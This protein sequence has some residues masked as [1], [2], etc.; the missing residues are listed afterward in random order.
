MLPKD[1]PP[2]EMPTIR[3]TNNKPTS[4]ESSDAP[5]AVDDSLME[6]ETK[7]DIETAS[8]DTMIFKT[9]GI[10]PHLLHSLSSIF[11]LALES[12]Q[13]F[14]K[15]NGDATG[16]KRRRRVS[17][18]TTDDMGRDKCK[19]KQDL[20]VIFILYYFPRKNAKPIHSFFPSS[21]GLFYSA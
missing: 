11:L 15:P 21:I 3:T 4:V 7:A 14:L 18:P 19:S 2:T 12:S 13:I 1:A 10:T 16:L 5:T 8:S 6:A 9:R 20:D 17:L